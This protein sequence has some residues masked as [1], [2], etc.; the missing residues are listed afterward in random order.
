ML[1][2]NLQPVAPPP[3]PPPF[4]LER[5]RLEAI[6]HLEGPLKNLWPSESADLIESELA[7][8]DEGSVVHLRYRSARRLD[9]SVEQVI[10]NGLK[11]PL[12]VSDLR[13]SLEYQGRPLTRPAS[14]QRK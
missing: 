6:A 10:A 14:S 13:V 1:R 2:R 8:T 5:T 9:S 4:S 11:S 7:F 3:P 12:G